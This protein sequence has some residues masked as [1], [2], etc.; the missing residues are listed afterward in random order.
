M[1]GSEAPVLNPMEFMKKTAEVSRVKENNKK[2]QDITKKLVDNSG[3]FAGQIEEERSQL[4]C[5]EIFVN[6]GTKYQPDE[7]GSVVGGIESTLKNP[8][9]TDIQK[10][11][12][13]ENLNILGNTAFRAINFSFRDYPEGLITSALT[14]QQI[15]DF[16]PVEMKG[17]GKYV[18]EADSRLSE[19]ER[20]SILDINSNVSSI[21]DDE[22]VSIKNVLKQI[23]EETKEKPDDSLEKQYGQL[24]VSVVLENKNI[25]VGKN[26]RE[27]DDDVDVEP[28]TTDPDTQEMRGGARW[29]ISPENAAMA[30]KFMDDMRWQTYTP[31]EW[32][33][34]LG[35]T[36]EGRETQARI[37]YMVMVNNGAA[38]LLY[39]G[40]DLDKI[41]GNKMYS[42]F[43]NEKFTKLFNEDFKLVMSKMLHDLCEEYSD[44]NGKT[45]MRYKEKFYKKLF[46][47]QD[48]DGKFIKDENDRK[49]E[50]IF[51]KDKGRWDYFLDENDRKIEGIFGKDKGSMDIDQ[52][53]F[54]K[55]LEIRNYKEEMALFLANQNGRKEANYMDKMNAYTA[56][57]L[58]YMFGD[59]S[60]ADRMRL[61]PTF[62]GIVSDGVRTLNMEYKALGKLKISRNE[63]PFE[64][65]FGAEWFGGS[66]G[67]YVQTVMKLEED[68]KRPITGKQTLRENILDGTLPIFANKTCYGF[69]DFVCGTRDL[70][71]PDG[72]NFE[73]EDGE[74]LSTLLWK[75]A[76]FDNGKLVGQEKKVDFSFAKGQSDSLNF[77]RDQQE[78]A[79]LVF[80]CV[81]GKEDVRDVD[82]FVNK[83]RSAFGMVDLININNER[84]FTYTSNPAMWASILL[85]SF[86]PDMSRLSNE[87]IR[88]KIQ[89]HKNS[90]GKAVEAAYNIFLSEFL[91]KTLKLSNND[92][93]L[94]EIM[95]YM[96]LDLKKGENPQSFFVTIRNQ[97]QWVSD[98][99]QT[100]SLIK[101]QADSFNYDMKSSEIKNILGEFKK[102]NRKEIKNKDS[103]RI[104]QDLKRAID[105]RNV[106]VAKKLMKTFL[107]KNK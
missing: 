40:K 78:A 97:A 46:Y 17:L 52:D 62:T 81:T 72:K 34:K 39:A 25:E 53:V 55:I 64:S 47:K 71:K 18:V 26:Q 19:N 68:L 57:N 21:I 101:K 61:L 1:S 95:R 82:K 31:P 91:I 104:Y 75:Y 69:F 90:E 7:K 15:D 92:V 96:G 103:G 107:E 14:G 67:N 80:N 85:G 48:N 89:P 38:S 32:F 70:C 11:I 93:D 102:I 45:C 29:E 86:G 30:M 87:H 84:T 50:G 6:L 106:E 100:K 88:L 23:I 35:K 74:T 77:F 63:V 66:L 5:Q 94:N 12:A 73:K 37:E 76:D 42:A 41:R 24:A 79:A 51:G 99:T 27:L 83:V 60:L 4:V 10:T 105:S 3:I 65:I 22:N 36:E 20:K 98:K 56:W 13:T 33:K 44:Q 58:F 54:G 8:S 9:A 59:S 28:F 43:D 16:L 49:I 2:T